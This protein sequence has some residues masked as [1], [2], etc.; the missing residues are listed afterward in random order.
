MKDTFI[1][2]TNTLNIISGEIPKKK[3]IMA[4]T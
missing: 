1:N 4:Q 2:S 3:A